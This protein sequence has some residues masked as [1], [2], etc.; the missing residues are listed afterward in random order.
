MN[1]SETLFDKVSS[2]ENLVQSF[3]DCSRGKKSKMGYQNYLFAYGEKLKYIEEELKKTKTFRWFGYREFDVFEPKKRLVM[4][5]PYRD[6][7]VHTAIHRVTF[8]I[9]DPTM[10]ARTYA[11]RYDMGNHHAAVRLLEQLKCMGKDRYCIKLD[12]KKYFESIPHE[13]LLRRFLKM[14]PD[15]SLDQLLES[16]IA[17]HPRYAAVK[18]GIPI[19]NLTSQLF[20]NFYLSS[21]DRMACD[22]LG[23]DYMEDKKEVHAH[24]IRYM[25]DMVILADKKAK[26]FEVAKI[27]VKYATTEL[28]LSIPPQKTVVLGSDPIPFLGFVL[29]HDGYRPLK[30]NE[31]RFRKKIKRAT[32]NGARESLKAQ[33]LLSFE[34]WQKLE[35]LV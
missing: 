1:P 32:E 28:G 16:L 2:F 11:C 7:I 25:D 17:S 26:A 33:M 34:Q 30:R 27:L 8:P 35:K 9:V 31:R 24:Y 4:A 21:V 20:A 15:R 18:R 5:A 22:L 3:K 23:I 29:N 6:R 19:G 10:G 14:L 12:V 13:E